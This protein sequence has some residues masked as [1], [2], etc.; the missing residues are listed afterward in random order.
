MAEGREQCKLEVGR[1]SEKTSFCNFTLISFTHLHLCEGKISASEKVLL[2]L[3]DQL[4]TDLSF[5]N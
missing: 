3:G 5:V 4:L 1:R 2:I